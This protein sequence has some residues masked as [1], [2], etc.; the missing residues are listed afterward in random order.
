MSQTITIVALL[1][2]FVGLLILLRKGLPR[3]ILSTAFATEKYPCGLEKTTRDSQKMWS[4][5]GMVL[6]AL[7]TGLQMISVVLHAG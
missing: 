1:C 6:F 4:F 2:A 3:R 5:T 7:G